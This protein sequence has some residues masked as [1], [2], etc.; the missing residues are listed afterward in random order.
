[1]ATFIPRFKNA[2]AMPSPMP[3]A[4]PVTKRHLSFKILHV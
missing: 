1:M 4:P 3:L 2:F